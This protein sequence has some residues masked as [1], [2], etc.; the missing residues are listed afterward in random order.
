MKDIFML[1]KL[2]ANA[3]FYDI[4]GYIKI[5]KRKTSQ[6][7]QSVTVNTHI[8]ISLNEDI[9]LRV[10]VIRLTKHFKISISKNK[11]HIKGLYIKIPEKLFYLK[12]HNIEPA[13]LN[14][15]FL[16]KFLNNNIRLTNAKKGLN[17]IV[18]I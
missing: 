3:T 16:F 12:D 7:N 8:E 15:E 13:Q 9:D 4:F 17:R 10:R 1:G 6:I 18:N 11:Q 14:K 2:S 5:N